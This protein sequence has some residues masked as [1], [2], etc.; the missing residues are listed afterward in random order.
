MRM[1]VPI[2]KAVFDEAEFEAVI[3]PLKSGWVVQGPYVKQFERMFAEFT[4]SKYAKAV[5]SCTTALH[6]ALIALG[7]GDGDKVIVPSFTYVASANAIEYTG[8]TPVFCD[9]DLT[10]F[11]IDTQALQILLE[12]EAGAVKTIMPVTI[13]LL[14]F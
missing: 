7:V 5:S 2:T 1:E 9:I 11:N 3:K 13:G 14:R 12:R 8:A 10:T 4:G 6:L